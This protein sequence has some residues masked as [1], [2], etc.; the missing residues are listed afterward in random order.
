MPVLTKMFS[1]RNYQDLPN[2]N[3]WLQQDG[4]SPHFAL[5][6]PDFLNNRFP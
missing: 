1:N 4:A 3:I 2:D 6:V 5:P